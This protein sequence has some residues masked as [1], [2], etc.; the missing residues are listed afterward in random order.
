MRAKIMSME[1]RHDW[2]HLG[3]RAIS[4]QDCEAAI[5][6]L[7]SALQQGAPRP[8]YVSP[9]PKGRVS[10]SWRIGS[11]LVYVEVSAVSKSRLYFQW[12]GP[13]DGAKEGTISTRNFIDRLL[14]L[15]TQ[16]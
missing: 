11:N 9:S 5:L 8:D 1:R 3:A 16:G 4:K 13:T 7:Q 2:N 14:R 10:L 12:G 6:F 15:A